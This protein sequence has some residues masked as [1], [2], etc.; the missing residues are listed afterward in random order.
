MASEPAAAV[1]VEV[2]AAVAPVQAALEMEPVRGSARELALE[3][4]PA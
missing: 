2:V 4:E 1:E 3:P